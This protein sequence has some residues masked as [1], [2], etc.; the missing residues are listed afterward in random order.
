MPI[1][2]SSLEVVYQTIF[3]VLMNEKN[4]NPD[5]GSL[6]IILEAFEI[7]GTLNWIARVMEVTVEYSQNIQSVIMLL[8]YLIRKKEPSILQEKEFSDLVRTAKFLQ[9]I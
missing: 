5:D 1:D 7:Y 2:E 9:E 4:F 8:D 6:K 3:T